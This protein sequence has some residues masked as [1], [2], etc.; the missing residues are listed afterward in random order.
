[1]AVI[2]VG[3][4]VH[5]QLFAQA[6]SAVLEGGCEAL[7]ADFPQA[8]RGVVQ[9][10]GVGSEDGVPVRGQEHGVQA[11]GTRGVVQVGGG[12]LDGFPG[13]AKEFRG[14]DARSEEDFGG[15]CIYAEHL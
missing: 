6:G 1:M 4:A 8:L 2:S 11:G 10:N 12:G 5:L 3:N 14:A 15:V 13:A 7:P 9:G